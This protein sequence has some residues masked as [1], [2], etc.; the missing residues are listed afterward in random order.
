MEPLHQ[1][2]RQ[3]WNSLR[4]PTTD[5]ICARL[6]ATND[7]LTPQ[8]RL[9]IYRTTTRMAHTDALA[10]SYPC[11]EK[12]LG[13][14]YFR[15]IANQYF[16]RYPAT[17]Q[18]LNV[19]G[20]SFPSFLKECVQDRPELN[21]Y[22]YLPDLATLE[23]AYERAYYAADD[24][25]FDFSTLSALHHD[26]HQYICFEPSASLFVLE[27]SYPIHEIWLAN[28]GH[29]TTQAVEA[30]FEPQYSCVVREHFKP[31]IHKIDR[32]CWWTI[33]HVQNGLSLGE[34]ETLATTRESI[35]IQRQIPELIQKKWVCGYYFKT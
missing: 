26:R 24:P 15:Q 1:L 4:S 22:P 14:R 6:T 11:C 20:Q 3:F 29:G 18:N 16:Y 2:Q 28:Q 8:E 17:N 25:I 10:Q 35:D 5:S 21:D 12:I 30:I 7:K 19:Y 31:S 27:S 9:N 33:I 13:K 34:M 23:G 32:D